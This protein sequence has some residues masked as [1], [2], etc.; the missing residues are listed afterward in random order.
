MFTLSFNCICQLQQLF[1][2][3]TLSRNKIAQLGNAGGNSARFIK[4]HH[5]NIVRV[6]QH[7]CRFYE[8]ATFCTAACAHHNGG[9]RCKPQR[10][11]AANHQH[12]NAMVYRSSNV[13]RDGKPQHKHQHRNGNHHRHKYGTNF[14]GNTLNGSFAAGSF[15]HQH[16]DFRQRC[17]CPNALGTHHEIPRR[18]YRSAGNT[19]SHA[20]FNRNAFTR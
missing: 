3:N 4:C 1:A 20:L 11:G 17:F 9:R 12:A 15:I 14:V 7:F 10:A 2:L 19:A 18:V 8:H 5:G 6:F 13:L 16:D